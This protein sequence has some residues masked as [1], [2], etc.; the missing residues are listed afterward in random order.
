MSASTRPPERRPERGAAP[1]ASQGNASSA[2][3]TLWRLVAPYRWRALGISVLIAGAAGLSQ[4]GPQFVRYV[5]DVAIPRGDARLFLWIGVALVEYY[6]VSEGL[7]FAQM[8]LSF[9]FTQDVI[10][11]T[12]ERAYEHLLSLPMARFT[13][14][15]SGSLVSRVVSD[16]NALESMIQAGASRIIG[17]LFSILVVIGFLFAMNWQLA[18]VALVVIAVMGT[19]TVVF[20]GPLRRLARKIRGRVGEMTAVA[21]EAIGN[22][23]VVK[24]FVAERAEFDRFKGESDAYRDLN[25]ARRVQV[26]MMQGSIGLSSELG[27]AAVL[28]LGGWFVAQGGDGPA[29]L[30]AGELTAF[31]LYL[32]RLVGPVRFVLNF[33]NVLQSGVAALERIDDLLGEQPESSPSARPFATGAIRLENVHFRYPGA[34][35]WALR[36]LSLEIPAGATA[37]L[38]G[39]SGAGKSTVVRLLSRLYDPQEGD[40]RIGEHAVADFALDDLRRAVALVPQEP[41][42]FS[43]S[44]L[45]NIR[46]GRPEATEADARRAAELANAHEFIEALPRSYATPVGER[47]VKLSGGQKQRVAIARAILKDARIL[48]LDEA[49]SNLDSESEAVIQDALDGLF[50][51]HGDVTSLVIAHRLSTVQGADDIFVLQDGRLA[52][53]GSHAELLQRHGIYARLW[54][55][56]AGERV[57]R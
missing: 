17:Q 41:T 3:P 37:A 53:R 42:L 16:V 13:E 27:V 35:A 14:E 6:L 57:R 9:S 49:T 30:T 33:N 51:R 25:M 48:V 34:E 21:T 38:V 8:Y 12:R 43:G 40:V 39:P 52:E 54:S 26:G 32:N 36:G 55:I 28:L 47:G 56:Q 44:V 45:D 2:L 18:L 50:A 22:I 7:D 5:F 15:R 31:L 29:G 23:G 4:L 1:G 19:F 46:Y 20:Q 10:R 24:T 11:D